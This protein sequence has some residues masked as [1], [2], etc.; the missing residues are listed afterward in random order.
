[1]NN[2]P[3]LALITGAGSGLGAATA[4]LLA[5]K[6]YTVVLLDLHITPAQKLAEQ[7]KGFA[8][9][10]DVSD[11]TQVESVFE[12]IKAL[13]ELRV[14]VNCAGVVAGERI[15]GLQSPMPLAHFE[16]VI[17]INLIGTFNVMRCASFAMRELPFINQ[18][19]ERGVII[20]TASIAAFEGQFGQVAY[21]ASKGGVVSMT[22]PAARELS[23]LGIRVVAIA[24]GLFHTPMM[25]S[26]PQAAKE[27]LQ[28]AT[29][30]PKRLG[31]AAEFAQCVF[32][33]IQNSMYNGC[34]IRLDGG[35]RLARGK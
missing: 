28:Q 17:K 20:N 27:Q 32:N 35:V 1:M 34:V 24:P 19:G 4:Q 18:E 12:K 29:L 7:L 22:L 9:A 14:C 21:S 10:V 30:F 31:K 25:E 11:A 16:D 2:T 6:A 33:I 26:I 5:E 23:D 15:V 8:F 3:Q 13:G